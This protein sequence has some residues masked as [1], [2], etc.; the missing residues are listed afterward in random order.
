MEI[1]PTRPQAI[2]PGVGKS[3]NF[4]GFVLSRV[5][6][7][8]PQSDVVHVSLLSCLLFAMRLAVQDSHGPVRF[9]APRVIIR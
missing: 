6:L 7:R 9:A 4:R 2:M 1:L 3:A 8:H 5:D